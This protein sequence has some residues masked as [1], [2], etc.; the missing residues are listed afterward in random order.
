[1]PPRSK[2][3][4]PAANR[5]F[6]NRDRPIALFHAARADCMPGRHRILS[7][8]GIG[9]QG[10]TALCRKLR[11][12]LAEE[13][14][15]RAVWGHLDLEEVPFREPARGL[16][17][18]R[19]TLRDSGRIKF[20]A[21][22]VAI[23]A[24][25]EKAYPTEGVGKALKDILADS[26][27]VLGSIAD[28]APA[29]LDL[30][31]EL[32]AGL[33]LG[34][35]GLL[36]ARK[37]LKERGAKREFEA[38]QG[39]ENLDSTQ[40]LE[41]LPYFLG[42]DLCAHLVYEPDRP[43]VVFI[44]TYEALWSDKTDK[45]GLAAVETDEWVRELVAASPGVLFVIFGRD[46]LTWD[47]RFPDEWAGWLDDHHLLGGLSDEDAGRFLALIPI[48]DAAVRRAMIE[49]AKGEP[50]DGESPEQHAAR[51]AH[52]FYLDLSVD[53][54]LDI[55]DSGRE[56]VP[57]DF[58]GTHAKIL[59]RFLDYRSP[60]EQRTLKV[61]SGPRAFD[62]ELFGALTE[63][64]RTG[65]S[66]MDFAEFTGF[67]FV[68]QGADGRHRLHALMRDHLRAELDAETK[69]ELEGF[70]FEWYD[71]RCQPASP[72]D[73]NA[74]HEAALREAVYHRDVGDAEGA[75]AWFWER[76]QIFYEAARHTVRESAYR[77]ALDLAESQLGPE[78]PEVAHALNE[79]ALLLKATNR[80]AEAEPPMRRAL[81]IDE[82][83]FG[84]EHPNVAIGLNNLALLLQATHRPA[85]A[86][87]LM[88][89]ALVIVLKFTRATGHEHP[90]LRKLFGN[91][92]Q[93]LAATGLDEP[94]IARRL[95][96]AAAE[97]GYAPEE[98]AGLVAGWADAP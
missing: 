24:Y 87:P 67:S 53:T 70:L 94:A 83:S 56:P 15:R 22:D 78:H 65:L 43:P 80:L 8:H 84:P 5:E 62:R 3:D 14:P 27:G 16:L 23:A 90:E 41:K 45:T 68:E 52:P 12:I 37:K 1:M 61:L 51:G 34:V 39:L 92:R 71:A 36:F 63:R 49:G 98:W 79:L 75:L 31:Q 38:L 2:F 42:V 66:P 32:P 48:S 21:F 95:A 9:G 89:R 59:S 81:A 64:F 58:G 88:R 57:E 33:G 11:Q 60:P 17:Q 91:Y 26:E 97:T 25:W 74:G 76:V 50:E 82:A 18:L 47:R 54:W 72:R 44:D 10:K 77:W 86:E 55:L 7:F 96:E 20:T 29:W 28:N 30:A 40:L 85:A 19:K 13:D 69:A 93:V 73:V 46:R 4:R 35:K 6:V